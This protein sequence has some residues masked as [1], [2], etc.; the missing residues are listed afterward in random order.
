[1]NI[2]VLNQY[3]KRLWIRPKRRKNHSRKI[4]NQKKNKTISLI[5]GLIN[6][7]T[8]IAPVYFNCYTDTIVFNT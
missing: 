4:G 1:M 2:R 7:K 6:R 3:A 5:T 8:F